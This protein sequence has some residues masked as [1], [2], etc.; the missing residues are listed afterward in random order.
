MHFSGLCGYSALQGKRLKKSHTCVVWTTFF[1][2]LLAGN[3]LSQFLCTVQK[4]LLLFPLFGNAMAIWQMNLEFDTVK[5]KVPPALHG[6]GTF[7][8]SFWSPTHLLK[9]SVQSTKGKTHKWRYT[10]WLPIN[11]NVLELAREAN[12]QQCFR[13]AVAQLW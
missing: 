12:S 11:E 13:W 8:I 6:S 7:S 2:S 10:N 1:S 5:K 9:E 4:C 3:S